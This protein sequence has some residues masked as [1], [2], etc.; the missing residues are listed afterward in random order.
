MIWRG[1]L[2]E[3]MWRG[4]L[5]P[6]A[7]G[8]T[9]G[10][11]QVAASADD[12]RENDNSTSFNST[13][14][15]IFFSA[16]TTASIRRN[17]GFK[18]DSVAIAAGSTIDDVDVEVFMIFSGDTIRCFIRADVGSA[19]D[20]STNPDVTTRVNNAPVVSAAWFAKDIPSGV[21]RSSTDDS[22]DARAVLQAVIDDGGWASGNNAVILLEGQDAV[23][24]YCDVRSYDGN[25]SQ[26][27]KLTIDYTAG[28][29]GPAVL[30]S[31]RLLSG[32]GR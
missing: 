22:V 25:T 5:V 27:A 6:V 3:A 31:R 29:G 13:A 14:S 16:A 26:A 30:A 28:G 12:A 18:F 2:R 32:T 8:D 23:F 1:T 21:R 11:I 4:L 17:G 9:E 15:A 20:F 19:D 24:D 10:P 7:G